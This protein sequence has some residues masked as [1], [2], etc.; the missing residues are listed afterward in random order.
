MRLYSYWRSQATFRVRI[1]LNLKGLEV[2]SEYIDLTRDVQYGETYRAVNPQSVVPALIDGDGPPLT[3][4]LAIIEYLEEKHPQ[5]PLLPA[6]LRGRAR[7]RSLAQVFVCD[8]HPLV[9]PRVR[10]YLERELGLD[11]PVRLEWIRHWIT[12]ALHVVETRLASEPDT[13]RFCHGDTPTL[14]DICLVPQVNGAR[15]YG[16]DLA[17]FPTA[18]RIAE[19]CLKLD[20]F[21]SAHP[22][23]Q[24]DAPSSRS[25]VPG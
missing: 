23:R 22:R 4:S 6:G 10:S 19:A 16:C 20:A 2:E 11:E 12:T 7:V 17:P 8:S 24:P 5:P 21:A 1:A 13:G 14:A 18:L 3:Q 15:T 25:N 9:V